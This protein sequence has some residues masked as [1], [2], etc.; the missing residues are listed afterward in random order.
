MKDFN[1]ALRCCD[2]PLSPFVVSELPVVLLGPHASAIESFREA[3]SLLFFPLCW[4]ACL[5]GSRQYFDVDK[6]KFGDHDMAVVQKMYMASAKA[7][8][9]SPQPIKL[10]APELVSRP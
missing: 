8:V 7:F 5:I 3:E 1:W 9:V 10:D 2:S 6:E 4:Q